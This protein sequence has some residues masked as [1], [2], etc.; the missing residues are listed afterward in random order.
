M[1]VPSTRLPPID[2][3]D[4]RTV[5]GTVAAAAP[6][7]SSNRTSV[8]GSVIVNS[9]GTS[10][11]PQRRKLNGDSTRYQAKRPANVARRSN[12]PTAR[13]TPS[14][15]NDARPD[16]GGAVRVPAIT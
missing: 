11:A 14:P 9:G 13:S 8:V 15:V 5:G 3:T 6:G 12:T 10:K 1:L 2:S 4:A 16:A 7:Y